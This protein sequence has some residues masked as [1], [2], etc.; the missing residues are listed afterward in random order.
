MPFS[1]LVAPIKREALGTLF[2]ALLAF[3]TV[4][5]SME[6]VQSADFWIGLVKIV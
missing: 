5:F 2:R 6:F 4:E 1:R 3:I